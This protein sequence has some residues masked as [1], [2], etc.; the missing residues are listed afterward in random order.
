MVSTAALT[1]RTCPF[2]SMTMAPVEQ[3]VQQSL[4]QIVLRLQ[5]LPF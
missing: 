4:Q 3:A 1:A 2:W 5:P